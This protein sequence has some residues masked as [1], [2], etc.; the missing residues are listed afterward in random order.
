MMENL[1]FGYWLI[2][3]VALVVIVISTFRSGG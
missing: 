1:A 2:L 3:I